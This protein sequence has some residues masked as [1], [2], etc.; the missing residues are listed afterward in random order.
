M[1]TQIKVSNI[2]KHILRFTLNKEVHTQNSTIKID[3]KKFL[4]EITQ[5][6]ILSR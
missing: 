4:F 6:S 2:Y 1:W 5:N 3:K